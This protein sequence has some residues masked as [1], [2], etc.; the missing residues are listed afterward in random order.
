MC[1]ANERIHIWKQWD[2]YRKKKKT[3]KT[4]NKRGVFD[5]SIFRTER[6]P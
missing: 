6:F 3:E 2:Y 4:A 5:L 1:N